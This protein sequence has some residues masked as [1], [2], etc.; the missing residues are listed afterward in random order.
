MEN[1]TWHDV[2][3][4]LFDLFLAGA[5]MTEEGLEYDAIVPPERVAWEAVARHLA[6]LLYGEDEVSAEEQE[7][8]WPEWAQRRLRTQF[9]MS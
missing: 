8:H 3:K 1:R 4:L 7:T 9:S 6:S 5:G 2:A